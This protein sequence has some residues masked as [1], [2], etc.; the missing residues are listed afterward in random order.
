VSSSQDNPPLA[1]SATQPLVD[2]VDMYDR[3][4]A[5]EGLLLQMAT[6]LRVICLA[7]NSIKSH[8]PNIDRNKMRSDLEEI[9]ARWGSLTRSEVRSPKAN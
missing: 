2:L 5:V 7:L 6:D 8:T 3:L 9:W 4:G 1:P